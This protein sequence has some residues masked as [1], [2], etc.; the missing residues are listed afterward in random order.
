[1]KDTI[2]NRVLIRQQL[3][4]IGRQLASIASELDHIDH[5]AGRKLHVARDALHDAWNILRQPPLDE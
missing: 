3:Q 4:A 5:D 1:M 2:Q